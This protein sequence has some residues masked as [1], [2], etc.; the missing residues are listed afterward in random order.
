M[1][2]QAPSAALVCLKKTALLPE[3]LFFCIAT[4]AIGTAL[5][6]GDASNRRLIYIPI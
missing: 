1:R 6:M 5:Q 2:G 4:H 3:R